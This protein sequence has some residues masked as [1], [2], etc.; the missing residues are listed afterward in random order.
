MTQFA[1]PYNRPKTIPA[2]NFKNVK[3]CTQ[4]EQVLPL[5]RILDGL[6]NGTIV[7]NS[8]PQEFDIPEHDIEV[9]AGAT[10]SQ[11]NANVAAATVAD[12]AESAEQ[13]GD[14]ITAHPG[15]QYHVLEYQI[16]E[17]EN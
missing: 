16:P 6:K 9:P 10:A 12:L 1:T 13:S 5:K 3:S 17:D 4:P 11:T 14:I 2:E 7:L 15:F 8:H